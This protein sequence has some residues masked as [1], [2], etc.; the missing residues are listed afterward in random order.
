VAEDFPKHHF[1]GVVS[2]SIS[3]T[4]PDVYQAF[5]RFVRCRCNN[6]TSSFND[7]TEDLSTF[8]S[9]SMTFTRLY[10]SRRLSENKQ[11]SENPSTVVQDNGKRKGQDDD[12]SNER[13]ISTIEEGSQRRSS[14]I[15]VSADGYLPRQQGDFAY[16]D[17][18]PDED[19]E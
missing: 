5:C 1:Q 12:T 16:D 7:A 11:S 9:I 10:S 2:A 17:E 6:T 3:M 4:K 19:V 18:N 8:R 14:N 13:T 15:L